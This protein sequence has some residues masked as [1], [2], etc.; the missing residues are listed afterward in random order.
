MHFLLPLQLRVETSVKSGTVAPT[1][2][3]APRLTV[4]GASDAVPTNLKP[5]RSEQRHLMCLI[6]CAHSSK[7]CSRHVLLFI[8]G[9]RAPCCSVC[10]C[11]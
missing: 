6:C 7:R 4:D 3:L 9:R 5:V 11:C 10:T 2:I 8:A 1:D